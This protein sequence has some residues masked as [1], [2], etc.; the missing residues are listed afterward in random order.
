LLDEKSTASIAATEYIGTQPVASADEAAMF[1]DAAMIPEGGVGIYVLGS[2]KPVYVQVRENLILGR[3]PD[4]ETSVDLADLDAFNQGVSRR[5]AMLRRADFGFEIIDLA[6]SNGTWL[7]GLH[8]SPNLPYPLANGS[9]VRLGRMELVVIYHT[10]RKIAR[11][12]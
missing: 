9:Q 12:K 5:H 7:N 6:S 8:L 2:S 10:A 4:S 1:I 11:K 3:E